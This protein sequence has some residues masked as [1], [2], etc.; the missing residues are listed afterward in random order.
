[1]RTS[2]NAPCFSA[3][4][5]TFLDITEISISIWIRPRVLW[6]LRRATGIETS[7]FQPAIKQ[8]G[9]SEALTR[10]SADLSLSRLFLDP[11]DQSSK[12]SHTDAL[13]KEYISQ[14]FVR[15][16]DM[17]TCPMSRLNRYEHILWRQARQIVMTLKSLRS[18]SRGQRPKRPQFM[19][20][21]HRFP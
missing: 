3:F 13:R 19:S 9:Q 17:P 4:G 2:L 7:L 14:T 5:V 8:S 10:A 1:M 20:G 16:T 15:L 21:H 11:K 6:R 18:S 12:G